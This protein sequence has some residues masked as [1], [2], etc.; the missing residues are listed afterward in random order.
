MRDDKPT[1][2][3]PRPLARRRPDG[4]KLRRPAQRSRQVSRMARANHPITV[5]PSYQSLKLSYSP[6]SRPGRRRR[7]AASTL[8]SADY[9]VHGNGS[10][11]D[12]RAR[13]PCMPVKRSPISPSGSTKWASAATIS[14]SPPMTRR[15]RHAGR[16]QLCLPIRRV[17]T[18]AA[19]GRKISTMT[20][21]NGTAEEFRLR[22]AAEHRRRWSPI[23]A[24]CWARARWMTATAA[25]ATPSSA[26]TNRARPP[27]PTSAT[28]RSVSANES[29]RYVIEDGK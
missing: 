26:I 11:V 22:R 6:P 24:I 8:S 29:V 10:I 7:G 16:D 25:A 19:T 12:Q 21:D 4:G 17:P 15:R 23:R 5:E 28:D 3:F 13:R 9:R 27:P 14:W 1:K 18:P 2:S 20:L